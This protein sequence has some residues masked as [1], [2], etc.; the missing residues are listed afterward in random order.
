M[1]KMMM[2]LMMVVT[3]M[4]EVFAY[5][6]KKE[7]VKVKRNGSVIY[8]E[9][10]EPYDETGWKPD[11]KYARERIRDYN[12]WAI[13]KGYTVEQCVDYE[14]STLERL[15]RSYK[16]CMKQVE[17]P[18][19]TSLTKFVV[20]LTNEMNGDSETYEEHA[21]NN[22]RSCAWYVNGRLAKD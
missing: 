14:Y 11:P 10:T 15:R 3:M 20:D 2:V 19:V 1:K 9:K 22:V 12:K 16:F 17:N 6:P 13:R 4:V 8:Y 18:E 7:N 5:I 21:V